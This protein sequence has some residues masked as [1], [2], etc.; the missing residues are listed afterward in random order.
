MSDIVYTISVW[1]VPVL[2]AITLHEA[3]HG[4]VA[5]W[6]GDDTAKS[7]GRLSLN[8]LRHI[9]PFGTFLL[10]GLLLLLKAPVLFG[11]AKPVPVA[12]GRLRRPKRDMMLVALAGPGANMLL[13]VFAVFAIQGLLLLPGAGWTWLAAAASGKLAVELSP[14]A[15][16]QWLFDN[17]RNLLII[18]LVLAVFN[19]LP[20]PPL[21]GAKVLVGLL[22]PP[23]DL[24]FARLERFGMLILL[25]LLL[26]VPLAAR[27]LGSDFNPLAAVIGPVVAMLYNWLATL[28]GI[29]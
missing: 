3:A 11:Y 27:Q 12:F 15:I 13:A 7:R 10:P 18:N 6:R 16:P 1:L 20:I 28:A 29:V 4:Y 24:K 25:A 22:P 19:M 2:L 26:L 23:L 17:L 9:D 8:P 5:F 14:L 21:D